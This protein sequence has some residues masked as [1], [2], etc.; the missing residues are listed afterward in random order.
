MRLPIT[1]LL[2]L[3]LGIAISAPVAAAPVTDPA[4]SAI[5]NPQSAILADPPTGQI[6]QGHVEPV[7]TG[8]LVVGVRDETLAAGAGTEVGGP[9][10]FLVDED[11]LLDVAGLPQPTRLKLGQSVFLPAGSYHVSNPSPIPVRF[12]FIGTGSR[13]AVAGAAYEMEPLP[14]G[15]GA[16]L[17]YDVSLNREPFG[18]NSATPWHLHTG[19][20]F[21]VLDGGTWENRQAAGPVRRIPTPGYYIQLSGP[22]HQLAQVGSGGTALIVQFWPP[23]QNK[24]PGGAG[25]AAGTPTVL[26]VATAIASPAATQSP[27]AAPT[28]PPSSAAPATVP[29]AGT[30]TGNEA[31]GTRVP[32]A[33]VAEVPAGTS[34]ALPTP[35]PTAAVAATGTAVP[36]TPVPTA[37]LTAAT[38]T[39][40]PPT[41]TPAPTRGSDGSSVAVWVAVIVAVLAG[42]GILGARRRSR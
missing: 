7:P 18:P 16:G 20:A 10:G 15:P 5:R 14:W 31:V 32:A 33:T 38:S 27:A 26:T 24:S 36:L 19:P 40:V 42:T 21:G 3:L 23:G 25:L 6:A 30:P 35:A 1:P 4:Q 37:P 2:G 17:A 8:E 34:T 9:F 12:R 11:G 29:P 39:P 22:V 41:P 13:G 28:P